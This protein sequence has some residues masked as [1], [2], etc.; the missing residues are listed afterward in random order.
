[1]STNIDEKALSDYE[2]L[3]TDPNL[4]PGPLTASSDKLYPTAAIREMR[5]AVGWSEEI[6][7]FFG[8]M[9]LILS[10]SHVLVSPTTSRKLPCFLVTVA[11]NL[12]PGVVFSSII[13]S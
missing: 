5:Y 8:P 13:S 1:M 6:A 3:C 2:A 9:I 12:I 10:P 4:T 11:R 7:T